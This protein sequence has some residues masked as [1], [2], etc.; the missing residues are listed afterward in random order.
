ML[1]WSLR[2]FLAWGGQQFVSKV[3]TRQKS[4]YQNCEWKNDMQCLS[5]FETKLKVVIEDVLFRP[6]YVLFR[7]WKVL[8]RESR[9]Y[10]WVLSSG[11]TVGYTTCTAT[12]AMVSGWLLL[13]STCHGW[14]ACHAPTIIIRTLS[15]YLL[16]FWTNELDIYYSKETHWRRTNRKLENVVTISTHAI[17][18]VP[19]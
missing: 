12:M 18:L 14:A 19:G 11:Q 8:R 15:L 9:D 13:L 17:V 4:V 5:P 10:S 7:G 3:A 2:K 1:N 6:W 16:D